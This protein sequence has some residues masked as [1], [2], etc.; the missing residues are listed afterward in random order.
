MIRRVLDGKLDVSCGHDGFNMDV[1]I[2]GSICTIYG[3]MNF[4]G[5]AWVV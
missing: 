3:V 5:K 1:D 4:K 2:I